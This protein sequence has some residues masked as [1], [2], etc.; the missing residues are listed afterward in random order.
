MRR[1]G[2]RDAKLLDWGG[3]T[4]PQ[5]SVVGTACSLASSQPRPFSVVVKRLS[6]VKKIRNTTKEKLRAPW[7]Y[8]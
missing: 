1:A 2:R 8:E 7:G 3:G 4:E 6:N 5:A